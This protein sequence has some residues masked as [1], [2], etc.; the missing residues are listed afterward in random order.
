MI[1][2]C[3]HVRVGGTKVPMSPGIKDKL[4][5]VIREYGTGKDTLRCLALATRDSL[6]SKDQMVLEDSS[7]FVEYEVNIFI[8]ILYSVIDSMTS[9]RL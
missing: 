1:D 2:R 8:F 7:R 6:M 9:T 4:L 3:S 5:S